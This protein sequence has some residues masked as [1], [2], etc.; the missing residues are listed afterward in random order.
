MKSLRPGFATV[1]GLLI[2]LAALAAAQ[3]EDPCACLER[4][5]TESLFNPCIFETA[6]GDDD[7]FFVGEQ[8]GLVWVYDAAGIRN[9][10]PF[11]NVSD[12]FVLDAVVDMRGLLDLTFHPDYQNNRKIYAYFTDTTSGPP[13]NRLAEFLTDENNPDTVDM[14]TERLILDFDHPLNATSSTHHGATVSM[15]L[16]G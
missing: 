12:R 13:F 8:R 2:C 4:F 3:D 15:V 9:S 1:C 6:A 7:R 14:S 5:G 10:E 16:S 11:L